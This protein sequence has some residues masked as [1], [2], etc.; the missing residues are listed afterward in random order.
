[1]FSGLPGGSNGAGPA[2]WLTLLFV[3]ALTLLA[4]SGLVRMLFQAV[5]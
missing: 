2:T 3:A 4:M 1:V 5:P